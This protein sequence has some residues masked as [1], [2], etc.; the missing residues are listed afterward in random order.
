MVPPYAPDDLGSLHLD[1]AE[2]YLFELL[3]NL[4]EDVVQTT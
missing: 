2:R 4:G 3:A 1:H